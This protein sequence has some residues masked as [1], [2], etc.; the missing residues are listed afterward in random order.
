MPIVID[1]EK[2]NDPKQNQYVNVGMI[3]AENVRAM[4]AD[5][6]GDRE[7]MVTF[8]TGATRSAEST[9]DLEG[10]VN[11]RV[12]LEFGEY[13]ERHRLQKDGQLRASDNWQK[14]MPSDRAMRSLSR[15]YLDLWLI[16]RGYSARSEDCATKMQA[17]CAILFNTMVLMKN[18]IEEQEGSVDSDSTGYKENVADTRRL[19]AHLGGGCGM[20][21]QALSPEGLALTKDSRQALWATAHKPAYRFGA[22]PGVGEGQ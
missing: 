7:S 6:I 3:K 1:F 21:H 4:I 22:L 2:E 18:E 9:F 12:L 15:H 17:L 13:M 5:K 10:F 8:D 20:E 19:R 11:P 16:S 14:G